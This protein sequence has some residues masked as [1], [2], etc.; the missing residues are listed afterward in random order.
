MDVCSSSFA[1]AIIVAKSAPSVLDHTFT[2][3]DLFGRRCLVAWVWSILSVVLLWLLLLVVGLFIGLLVDRGRLS[4]NLPREDLPLFRELTGL[5]A[6]Q[7]ADVVD[8]APLQNPAAD[9]AATGDAMRPPKSEVPTTI[10]LSHDELGI[11]PS[12][13]RA[14]H[15]FGGGALA[16]LFHNVELLQSNILAAMTLLLS[17][18]LLLTARA[19]ALSQLRQAAQRAALESVASLRRNVH[20]QALRLGAE[21]LDGSGLTMAKQMFVVDIESLRHNLAKRIECDVRFSLELFCLAVMA[22]SI[23]P[24]M[25]AQ[26]LLFLGVVWYHLERQRHQ[27]EAAR[28]LAAEQAE[29]ELREQADGFQSARLVRGLGIEQVEHDH[30]VNHLNRFHDL[31]TRA[32]RATAA[33]RHLRGRDIAACAAVGALLLFILT[34]RVLVQEGGLSFAETCVF[35]AIGVLAI[36]GTVVLRSRSASL[37]AAIVTAEKIQT[38]LEQIPS[39]SQA[40]GARFL[41]PLGKILHLDSVTYRSP[42]GRQLLNELDL[43]LTAGRTYS[44]VSLDPVECHALVS[45]LPRFIEPQTG[46]ILFDGED[47]AWATLESLR[48]ETIFVGADDPLLPGNILDNIRGGRTDYTLQQAME[49][50]KLTH[51]HNF[52]VTLFDGYESNVPDRADRMDV[53][54]RFRL[55]LA[56][57][58]IRNPAVLIIE[59][60]RVSLDE[61]TKNLLADAYDR[62]CRDRTVIFLPGRMSTV[63][64]CDQVIVLNEGRV[65]AIGPQAKLVS[66][67]PI[68]R[69]WEYV[70]FNEFRHH[71]VEN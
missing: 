8:R 55:G 1:L 69:H 15:V 47:I 26:F 3:H 43:T 40:V 65:A 67:S 11:L 4:V 20:R 49:A 10:H 30:F 64:L 17:G 66:I 44:L 62:I 41:Q 51:A 5:P 36:P 19:I 23:Q 63:R 6:G 56:R 57:A 54:Q 35:L 18:G 61:D 59:E 7:E 14:R 32:M 46:R 70:N 42:A 31:A 58:M 34:T 37:H 45:L 33:A 48:A 52:I 21:D 9:P 12:V 16:W 38:F 71:V 27:A 13:W 25:S 60:P 22:V 50:A 53:S 39:V 68:Y 24:L 2:S 29:S 28:Q